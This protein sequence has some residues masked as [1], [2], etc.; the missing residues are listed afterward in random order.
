MQFK[1]V[2][3][4][5]CDPDHFP[6]TELLEDQL[7]KRGLE[8]LAAL[9]RERHGFVPASPDGTLVHARESYRLIA[10]GSERKLLPASVVRQ[11]ADQ[12]AARLE[13]QLGRAPGK[14]QVRELRE[15]VEVELLARA[16]TLRQSTR[17][18]FDLDSGFVLLDSAG[19]KFEETFIEVWHQTVSDAPLQRVDFERSPLSAM[20]EWV[21][22]GEAPEFFSIDQEAEL[23]SAAAG[24]AT[25]RYLRHTL[26]GGEIRR[27]VSNGKQCTRLAL[28]WRERLSFL[29][30]EDGSLKRLQWVDAESDGNGTEV[31]ED[32]RFDVDFV[33]SSGDLAGLCKDLVAALGGLAS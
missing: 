18:W 10:L 16:F 7:A 26:D 8:P 17:V 24:Q 27:H 1:N 25:V 4:L 20:T 32:E 15:Q 11:T 33:L 13:Q 19:A 23:R 28:T 22:S 31:P 9:E 2:R 30:N 6:A 3:M 21:A 29:L 5:R 12:R 14:R